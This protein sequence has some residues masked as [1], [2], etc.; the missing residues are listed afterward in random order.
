M[1]EISVSIQF[2]DEQTIDIL[3]IRHALC[4]YLQDNNIT[5]SKHPFKQEHSEK[6]AQN[7]Q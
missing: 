4:S 3:T 2:D 6:E 5:V 1:K 7:E